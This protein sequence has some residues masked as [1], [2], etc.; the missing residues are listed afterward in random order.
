MQSKFVRTRAEQGTFSQLNVLGRNLSIDMQGDVRILQG[1]LLQLRFSLHDEER[2]FDDA[3]RN[4]MPSFQLRN[5]PEALATSR[6]RGQADRPRG[7]G[8]ETQARIAGKTRG[9]SRQEGGDEFGYQ[10]LASDDAKRLVATD[11]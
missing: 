1:E 2:F 9:K 3:A 8:T 7:G 6:S 10:V 4:A 11:L 5:P